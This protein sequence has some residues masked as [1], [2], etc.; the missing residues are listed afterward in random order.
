MEKKMKSA[1]TPP[2]PPEPSYPQSSDLSPEEYQ[3]ML[4]S[5]YFD[6]GDGELIPP[7]ENN[8]FSQKPPGMQPGMQRGTYDV[9]GWG[10]AN[11]KFGANAAG[12]PGGGSQ[13]AIR[14]DI[15]KQ[16]YKSGK[17]S[18]NE[19][20]MN[21]GKPPMEPR[22]P[23]E[24]PPLPGQEPEEEP[25]FLSAPPSAAPPPRDQWPT[26]LQG[27]PQPSG[28]SQMADRFPRATSL[29]SGNRMPARQRGR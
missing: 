27:A 20:L 23:M 22:P 2:A 25:F 5:G 3:A 26:W 28:A 14:S 17:Q 12:G 15:F 1:P 19:A 11:P 13:D 6:A 4:D 18:G 10:A 9:P 7:M 29:M 21:I 24:M 8:P 16:I